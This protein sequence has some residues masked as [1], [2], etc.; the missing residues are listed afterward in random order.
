MA[1]EVL[2]HLRCSSPSA[3]QTELRRD[4]VSH[5]RFVVKNAQ[6][7]L[8]PTLTAVM[9][10]EVHCMN[11]VFGVKALEQPKHRLGW[12]LKD[13]M[14]LLRARLLRAFPWI[15]NFTHSLLRLG[16]LPLHKQ[17]GSRV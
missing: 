10:M 7:T 16:R 11:G 13:R 3:R 1:D 8:A 9:Q 12:S 5:A 4:R 17:C 6:L 2:S 15:A 14:L